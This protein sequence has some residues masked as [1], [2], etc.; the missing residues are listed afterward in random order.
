MSVDVEQL[1]ARNKPSLRF[2]LLEVQLNDIAGTKR[3]LKLSENVTL[4]A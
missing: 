4:S 1:F 3:V 2:S